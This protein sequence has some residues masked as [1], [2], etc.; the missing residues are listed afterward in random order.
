ML[1]PE[2]CGA[3]AAAG[4]SG[5]RS[6]RRPAGDSAGA[7]SCK[8]GSDVTRGCGKPGARAQPAHR[9]EVTTTGPSGAEQGLEWPRAPA[10][11]AFGKGGGRD[12]PEDRGKN[13]PLRTPGRPGDFMIMI[14]LPRLQ[15]LEHNRRSINSFE[16]VI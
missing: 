3:T 8:L 10:P 1:N 16:S 4:G 6:Q 9:L 7:A 15:R 11:R 5:G 2:E 14:G 13:L 12:G